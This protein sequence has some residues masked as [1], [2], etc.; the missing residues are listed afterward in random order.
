MQMY[1]QGCISTWLPGSCLTYLAAFQSTSNSLISAHGQASIY[2]LYPT[3]P[4]Q[5]PYFSFFFQQHSYRRVF[6]KQHLLPHFRPPT[7]PPS[8][9]SYSIGISRKW[10]QTR[11][12]SSKITN[13]TLGASRRLPSIFLCASI[14]S[15]WLLPRDDL[16]YRLW[17]ETNP[18][19]LV[20]IHDMHIVLPPA[21]MSQHSVIIGDHFVTVNYDLQ[22]PN[23]WSLKV[24]R[25]ATKTRHESTT[26][27]ITVCSP[28]TCNC[29]WTMCCACMKMRLVR[30]TAM[31][32]PRI[33]L[34]DVKPKNIPAEYER[35]D[36][37]IISIGQTQLVGTE[38]AALGP[39]GCSNNWETDNWTWLSLEHV[40]GPATNLRVLISL[41]KAWF[42]LLGS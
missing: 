39:S 35:D 14:M 40:H 21:R 6:F 33:N 8:W 11:K 18:P 2:P 28:W 31:H 37:P 42:E 24:A 41:R 36:D 34:A 17:M 10:P 25:R 27:S 29:T 16:V 4:R 7:N 3:S 23:G 32:I 13:T 1:G 26:Y 5:F 22:W 30:S 12:L 9:P 15:V 19:E 20:Y 38:D